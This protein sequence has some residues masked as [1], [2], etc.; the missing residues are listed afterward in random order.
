MLGGC[1]RLSSHHKWCLALAILDGTHT[2]AEIEFVLAQHFE[3][4]PGFLRELDQRGYGEATRRKLAD[5]IKDSKEKSGLLKLQLAA[6]LDF[7]S[8]VRTTTYE[9]EGDRL[10]LLLVHERIE[11]L[12][13]LGRRIIC[14]E[15]GCTPILDA[16]LRQSRIKIN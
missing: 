13:V 8:V 16:V 1:G 4:L 7:R 2:K 15:E 9:L 6:M 14:G 12:R 5:I 3:K 10:E 11:C